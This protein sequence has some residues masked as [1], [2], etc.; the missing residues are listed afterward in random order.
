M[1]PSL[2]DIEARVDRRERRSLL[3]TV[4][5][6]LLVVA[7]AA[8]LLFVSVGQVRETESELDEAKTL[9]LALLRH[10]AQVASASFHPDGKHV[11]TASPDGA[12]RVWDS[13]TGRVVARLPR[14]GHPATPISSVSFSPDGRLFVTAGESGDA[15][16]WDWEN[17]KVLTALRHGG[18]V[19]RAEFDSEGR[20]VVTASGNEARVWD[21]RAAKVVA[22]LRHPMRVSSVAFGSGDRVVTGSA[23]RA[24]VWTVSGTQPRVLAVLPRAVPEG[25][26][27]PVFDADFAPDGAVVIATT[28]AARIYDVERGVR[29]RELIHAGDVTSAAVSPDGTLVLTTSSAGAA[30]IWLRRNLK[31]PPVVLRQDDASVLFDAGFSPDGERVVTASSDG[32]AE[33]YR[34][35]T[36]S[37]GGDQAEER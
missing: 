17:G 7:A 36:P 28:G 15:I 21:W 9:L 12:A 35:A 32:N 4:A 2:E 25:S 11:V 29:E 30:L 3:W 19:T 10:E 34:P 37:R 24:R 5:L 13:Q 22:T 18:P 26:A 31:A 33:V 16:V 27:V 6:T 20:L 23:D 8:T 14:A 1:G